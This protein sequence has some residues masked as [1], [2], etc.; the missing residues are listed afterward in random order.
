MAKPETGPDG[1]VNMMVWQC[2]IPGKTGVSSS[3]I[4]LLSYLN[5]RN[6][7]LEILVYKLFTVTQAFS[8]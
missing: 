5:S 8:F 3:N 4:Y 7:I 6:H 2:T 1:S